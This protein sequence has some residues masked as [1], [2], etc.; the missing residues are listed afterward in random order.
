[1][2]STLLD[3]TLDAWE[4][5]DW[6]RLSIPEFDA[7]MYVPTRWVS[8]N[9][10]DDGSTRLMT[11]DES[12]HGSVMMLDAPTT[13]SV[14]EKVLSWHEYAEQPYTLRKGDLWVTTARH[15]DSRTYMRSFWSTRHGAWVSLILQFP[16]ARPEL[17]HLMISS[18]Q[19]GPGH[20]MNFELDT[21]MGRMAGLHKSQGHL[22]PRVVAAAPPM[23]PPEKVQPA[24]PAPVPAA[25]PPR[26]SGP[27]S[28]GSGFFI[29]AQGDAMTNHHVIDDCRGMTMNG[30]PARVMASSEEFDLALVEFTE[31]RQVGSY[32][33]F[34]PSAGRLNSDVTLAAF[35]CKM[36]WVA[37]TS[38]GAP[39]PR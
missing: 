7:S 27:S 1:M 34:S 19:Q 18:F 10:E 14:H 13:Q 4:A 29:N 37:S 20:L 36:C 35:R 30:R 33:S 24:A 28:N 31:P 25:Q 2:A 39:S 6:R 38:P 8:A 12:T 3:E 26:S 21:F 9:D 11:P 23:M 5:G 17:A 15:D 16:D 22:S 32:L